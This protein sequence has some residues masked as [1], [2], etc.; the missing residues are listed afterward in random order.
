MGLYI[1]PLLYCICKVGMHK[2]MAS[3]ILSGSMLPD[4]HGCDRPALQIGTGSV[5]LF[6]SHLHMLRNRLHCVAVSIECLLFLST[7]SDCQIY[8]LPLSLV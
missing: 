4:A 3:I 6:V 1:F 8:L 7:G 5:I 2:C